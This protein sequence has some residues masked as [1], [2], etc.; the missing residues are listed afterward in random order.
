MGT[1]GRGAAG[2]DETLAA[3]NERRVE[4]LLIDEGFSAPGSVSSG[5]GMLH[6]QREGTSPVDDSELVPREDIVE[7]AIQ[8]ALAQSADVHVVRYHDDLGVH[9][10]IGA[11]LRF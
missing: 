9:G 11:I 8:S 10:S 7:S 2:L 5:S 4:T 6:A 1:G 3:L